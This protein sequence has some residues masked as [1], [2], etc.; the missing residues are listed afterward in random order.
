VVLNVVIIAVII[1]AGAFQ[2]SA[3]FSQSP[4]WRATVTP[5][6]SIIGSGF[7][8]LA[9]ILVYAYGSKAP[10]VMGALV[11]GAYLFGSAIR[12]NITIRNGPVTFQD[13]IAEKLEI[14]ASW[15]LALAF[16]IS[17][18]YYLNLFGAF[19]LSL[20]SFNSSPNAKLLTS[21]VFLIILIVGYTRG[22]S[23]LE[24]MEYTA[25]TIKLAIIAGL[26]VGLSYYC[27]AKAVSSA[28]VVH[29]PQLT[30]WAAVTLAFGL[31][32]T[33]QGFET[34]RYLGDE[35]SAAVR[36]KSMQLAQLVAAAIYMVYIT[37]FALSFE[38]QEFQLTETA[39]IDVMG[40]V[41][42]IL[43]WILVAGALAAQ[44]SAAIADTSGSG[45][46]IA[47]LTNKRVNTRTAYVLLVT[48]GL[49]LT[50]N[51]DVFQIISYASRAFALYYTLQAAI[52]AR[53][54]FL[55]PNQIWRGCIFSFLAIFGILIVVF[56]DSVKV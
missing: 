12:F 35:Y 46:L 2:F 21:F 15:A 9:P 22:F 6:A 26:L 23:A 32:I 29:P 47:E 18:T 37:L 41:A 45:G 10:L 7:L 52:A 56:G 55:L 19:G 44:F 39:I 38:H 13:Y 20:T 24:K 30:G 40:L 4:V 54:A 42:P 17:V 49:L 5:L 48:I 31:I 8:V 53:M 33:V 3:R 11:F 50:W 43:P 16:I 34:S 14:V 25:V 27:Y 36:V 51:A 28:L 1:F